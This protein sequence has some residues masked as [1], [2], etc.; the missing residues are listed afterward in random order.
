MDKLTITLADVTKT[1]GFIRTQN[2]QLT[3]CL[4]EINGYM[5]QLSSDWQSPAGEKIRMRFHSML[6]VFD[7]YKSIVETYAKFLDQTVTTY[8]SMEAQLNANAES[9]Q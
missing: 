5:N 2:E 4:Q 1:A 7:N 8:Q 9:F 3:S 6:P